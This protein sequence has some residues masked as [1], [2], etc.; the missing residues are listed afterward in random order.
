MEIDENAD[1]AD[2]N[3]AATS[4][5]SVFRVVNRDAIKIDKFGDGNF[6]RWLRR[7]EVCATAYGLDAE[8]R[9]MHLPTFLKDRPWVV[10]KHCEEEEIEGYD[11]AA[12]TNTR[13]KRMHARTGFWRRESSIR[14]D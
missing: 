7:F 14:Q 11:V 13:E 6:D 10:F 2:A 12:L 3:A 4:A 1:N 9:R 8:A 5:R